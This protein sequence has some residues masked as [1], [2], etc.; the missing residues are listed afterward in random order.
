MKQVLACGR[1]GRLEH[2]SHK[3]WKNYWVVLKG[4]QL[5]LYQCDEKDVGTIDLYQTDTTVELDCCLAQAVPEHAKL[6]HVFGISTQNGEAYYFQVILLWLY[7][8]R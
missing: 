7:P 2:L 1:S 4:Y 3:K 8:K 5:N 6:E